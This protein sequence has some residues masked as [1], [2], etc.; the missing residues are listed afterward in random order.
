MCALIRPDELLADVRA[1][2]MFVIPRGARAL[3]SGRAIFFRRPEMMIIGS[4]MIGRPA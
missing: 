1:D 2:E 4:M 3:R